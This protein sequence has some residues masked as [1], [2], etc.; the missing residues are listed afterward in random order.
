MGQRCGHR[1]VTLVVG[2][3][4]GH[5]EVGILHQRDGLEELA[6]PASTH[7]LPDVE[8]DAPLRWQLEL[9]VEAVAALDV[10]G[11]RLCVQVVDD[12]GVAHDRIDGPT[13]DAREYLGVGV[14]H[15]H[16]RIG[17]ARESP[18]VPAQQLLPRSRQAGHATGLA[19]DVIGVV[20]DDAAKML[21]Q[22]HGLRERDDALSLPHV[23][24]LDLAGDDLRP[25]A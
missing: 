10:L 21:A 7:H 20:D 13:Q 22:G 17:R 5:H 6:Q 16:D 12:R 19:V 3:E 23:E 11:L 24:A 15:G 9:L 18:L 1:A 14:R 2:S 8:H 25:G 4:A